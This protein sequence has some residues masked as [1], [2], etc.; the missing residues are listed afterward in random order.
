MQRYWILFLIEP[1]NLSETMVSIE[2]QSVE[3]ALD[4]VCKEALLQPV[5]GR[6]MYDMGC[7]VDHITRATYYSLYS[8]CS[9][10]MRR[11]MSMRF[12]MVGAK[13]WV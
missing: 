2:N 6:Q 8:S 9:Y 10:P 11:D 5:P 3:I 4:F 12:E 7:G 13:E 1:R